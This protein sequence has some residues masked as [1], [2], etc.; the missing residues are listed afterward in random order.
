MELMKYL[1]NNQISC[2]VR[3]KLSVEKTIHY[4]HRAVRYGS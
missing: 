3:D 4:G 1:Y 2:P